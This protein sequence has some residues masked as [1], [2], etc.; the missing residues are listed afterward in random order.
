MGLDPGDLG[1][2]AT[3]LCWEEAWGSGE[4]VGLVAE[5]V[6]EVRPRGWAC[7]L[8]GEVRQL[9]CRLLFHLGEE[10]GR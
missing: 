3:P 9:P 5:A 4:A 7:G 1:A 8:A 10:R 6:L 2:S